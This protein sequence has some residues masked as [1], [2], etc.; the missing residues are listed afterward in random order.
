[1]GRNTGVGM[2]FGVIIIIA[3]FIF[4]GI[5][6]A[7][8]LGDIDT[9]DVTGTE[10]EEASAVVEPTVDIFLGAFPIFTAICIVM[11]ICVGF[12]VLIRSRAR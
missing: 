2:L 12:L 9:S 10:L 5:F 4:G 11:L 3:L 7:A 8:I 6:I 1:M